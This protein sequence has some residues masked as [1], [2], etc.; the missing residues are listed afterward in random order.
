MFGLGGPVNAVDDPIESESETKTPAT[1]VLLTC[2]Y[3]GPMVSQKGAHRR[4]RGGGG[5][6]PL[7]GKRERMSQRD[8]QKAGR[9][10]A[11]A[12]TRTTEPDTE[13]NAL[14]IL[15]RERNQLKS[16]LAL[17]EARVAAL[18]RE[19]SDILNRIDWVIDSLHNLIEGK[20]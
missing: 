1:P 9:A 8:R 13:A 18:E 17:A 10:E 5:F 6:T 15:E 12:G 16:A 11:R 7:S 4:P 19:R 2:S 3:H 14:E 20:N